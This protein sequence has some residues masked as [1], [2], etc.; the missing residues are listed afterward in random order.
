M[1]RGPAR[2]RRGAKGAKPPP[3]WNDPAEK[4]RA[5]LTDPEPSAG[6]KI[7]RPPATYWP[8]SPMSFLRPS[9]LQNLRPH[10]HMRGG[11]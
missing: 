8:G 11:D 2:S 5:Y 3:F 7:E 9:N 4:A 1:H 6:K 10:T